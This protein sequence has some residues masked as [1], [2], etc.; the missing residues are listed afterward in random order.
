MENKLES[1]RSQL[2]S[3]EIDINIKEEYIQKL[4]SQINQ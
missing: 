2:Q 1:Y 4:E 3:V